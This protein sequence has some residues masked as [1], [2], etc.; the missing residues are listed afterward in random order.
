MNF[1]QLNKWLTLVA[2]FGVIGGL[3]LVAMQMN[4]NTET[5]RL[6]NDLELN[7]AIAAGELAY[8]GDSAPT[9]WANAVLHPAD[10]T[11]AQLGQVWAYLHNVMLAA[12][13]NWLAYK[14]GQASEVSW[15]H[16][17]SQAA[18]F[19]G[20]RVGRIW[21]SHDKFEYETGFVEQVDA[22]L[23]GRD[24]LEVEHVTRQMLDEIRSLEPNEA[25]PAG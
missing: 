4:F 2:N 13:N 14:D 15:I 18:A 25:T 21:W 10:L 3:V 9:A 7:R 24:P 22:A 6:Q 19:I 8:L 1:D 17:R 23:I 16:A 12:Q 11:D 5:I 20:F